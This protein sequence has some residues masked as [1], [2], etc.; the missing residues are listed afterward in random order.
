MS[1][2][3]KRALVATADYHTAGEP[4][5]IV[6]GGVLPPA[7]RRVA[8][9]RLDAAANL[10]AVRRLLVQEPRGHAGMYGCFPTPP[11]D[12]G[13]VLGSVFFH[14]SGFST[15]CGHGTIALA[16]W[17]ADS[18]LVGPE[19]DRLAIDVPSGRVSAELERRADGSVA[20]VG[21]INVPSFVQARDVTVSGVP[22]PAG[23]AGG[24]DSTGAVTAGSAAT[25]TAT[26]VAS[27]ATATVE[28]DV[29]VDVAF[30]GAFYASLPARRLG[31]SVEPGCLAG[32][33]AA[34]R[35]IQA[36]LDASGVARHALDPNL[37][38]IYGVT[39]Y[40]DL[41]VPGAALAQRSVTVFGD[42]QIDRSPCGSGT[43]ARLALLDGEGLARGDQLVHESIVGTRFTARVVGEADADGRAAV[44]TEVRGSASLTGLHHFVLDPYDEVGEGFRLD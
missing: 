23:K 30:G 39:I 13:A 28:V 34:G 25:A 40:E 19:L 26:T 36:A 15:A 17:A 18:G 20:S 22:V 8:E 29:Q 33:I 27:T 31:L 41:T 38:G 1:A 21:F 32:L 43:S 12:E 16:T 10:D 7:G 37:N 44:L 4:F 11:D 2:K 24:A 35:R 14:Q 6:T 3:G 5:R 42:G 9:R